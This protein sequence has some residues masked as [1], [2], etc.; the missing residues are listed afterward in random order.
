MSKRKL[1]GLVVALFLTLITVSVPVMGSMDPPS[2]E[3]TLIP[4]ASVVENKDVNITVPSMADVLFSFDLS[5]S[6]DIFLSN[7]KG[8]YADIMTG[9]ETLG[10]DMDYGVSS[11]SDY[12]G[13]YT[14]DC[15]SGKYGSAGYL[16]YAYALN[17]SVT[18]DQTKVIAAING[19]LCRYG[20]DDAEA[21]SRVFY[22]SYADPAPGYPATGWRPGAKRVMVHLGDDSI[23]HD[24]DL[25]ETIPGTVGPW[26]T[27][28]DPGRDEVSNTTDDL[29]LL[30][31]LAD[32]KEHNVTLIECQT[33]EMYKNY[34]TVWT[35]ITG[36]RLLVTGESTF[37]QDVIGA[38]TEEL[39]KNVTNVHILAESGYE[40]WVS[41]AWSYS[42]PI[43]KVVLD[44]PVTF[45]VP[46]GTSTGNYTFNIY[47]VDEDG[48][49]YGVQNVT[50]H[51]VNPV[52]VTHIVPNSGSN[53]GTV[54]IKNLGGTGF[55][56]G[57]VVKLTMND[58]AIVASSVIVNSTGSSR[59]ITC[60]FDLTGAETGVWNVVVTNPDGSWGSLVDGFT[61]TNGVTKNNK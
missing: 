13:I 2:V 28:V 45:T 26:T 48:V 4:G 17:Q 18:D 47:I 53:T 27:G 20:S 56:P 9:L 10:V 42:G 58:S 36:G 34:W 3:F 1:T 22:E 35:G 51:V 12:P 25:N 38:I 39:T 41:S 8:D 57:A 16:D 30:S 46:A 54:V 21:Y 33:D 19:L 15:Y 61:I 59:K 55:V 14:S 11:H 5:S 32:M 7:V 6:M 40:S 49:N 43:N 44:I 23:P 24:C 37:A 29:V 50:I 31:V 52:T 60:T